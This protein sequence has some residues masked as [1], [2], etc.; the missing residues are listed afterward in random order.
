MLKKI[1]YDA[2]KYKWLIAISL[3]STIAVT[4][5]NLLGPEI[6]RRL[7]KLV[8]G[9]DVSGAFKTII[10]MGCLLTAV[11]LLRVALRFCN[12]Y[13]SH[14]A[15]HYYV[16][17]LRIKLYGH[18][19]KLSLKY[20]TDKQTGQLISRVIS[21]AGIVETLIAHVIPDFLGGVLVFIGVT[22][23]VFIINPALALATCIPL[24]FIAILS[25]VFAKKVRPNFKK[26][27]KNV[28]ELSAEL[29]DNFSGIKEIQLF[30]Q[31]EKELNKIQGASLR[32]AD[33]IVEALKKSAVFHPFVEFLTSVGTIIV[34]IFGG[35]L[36]INFK[37]DTADIVAFLLYASLF[38]A[39]VTSFARI[40]EDYQAAIAGAERV[41]EVLN[42]QPDIFDKENA[43]ELINCKGDIVFENV[44]FNYIESKEVLKNI[45]IEIKSGEMLAVVGPTGV[46]KSTFAALIPRFYD[47]SGGSVK[48]DGKDVKDLKLKSLRRNISMV[49]QDV[50]LFNGTVKENI[51]YAA[52]NA[53]ESEIIAAAKSANIHDEIMEMQD[54]YDTRI[55]ERGLKLSG[56][57]KQRLS[58]A[59]AVLRNSPILILDEAT[60]SVDIETEYK[61]QSAIGSLAG[62]RTIIVIAHR[63]STIKNADKIIVLADGQLSE[64][65]THKELI[66]QNGLYSKLVKM[67]GL[68]NE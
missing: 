39:P 66:K 10:F 4:G 46:G 53:D 49:L 5:L 55:G 8:D 61:I 57:Q 45:N 63:L 27:Q 37:I 15:A 21:D 68:N 32:Y 50:F 60:A 42:V 25:V 22:V 28:G 44:S 65:G 34:I 36:A 3:I 13:F 35:L 26:A 56:G 40:V 14:R 20:Y 51:G 18:L 67:Q 54:G 62:S 12:S 41:Y 17:D 2:R 23:I 47:C 30:A 6:I 59:R 11:Y 58:I 7:I 29:A 31:E 33:T 48:V 19:Q 16:A 43:S 38:Y 1:F 52:P 64:Q 24:P 9:G